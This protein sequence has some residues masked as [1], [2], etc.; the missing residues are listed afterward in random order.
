[1]SYNVFTLSLSNLYIFF[2]EKTAL[3]WANQHPPGSACACAQLPGCAKNCCLA[4]RLDVHSKSPKEQGFKTQKKQ[5]K[6][7]K[8]KGCTLLESLKRLLTKAFIYKPLKKSSCS[9]PFWFCGSLL[10][11][12]SRK[13]EVFTCFYNTQKTLQYLTSQPPT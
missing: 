6:T 7:S 10:K 5:K 9:N 13:S 12:L 1:M 3:L 8:K 2:H 11:S 4:W